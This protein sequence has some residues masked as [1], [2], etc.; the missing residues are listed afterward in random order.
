M[1][2]L[3]NNRFTPL[4]WSRDECWKFS[5]FHFDFMISKFFNWNFT[6]IWILRLQLIALDFVCHFIGVGL[7][8]SRVNYSPYVKSSLARPS[9]IAFQRVKSRIRAYQLR[10]RFHTTNVCCF[11]TTSTSKASTKTTVK[12][13]LLTTL[14]VQHRILEFP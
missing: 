8:N 12:A 7:M 13:F 5:W 2:I 3:I 6:K 4:V 1:F 9:P 14:A 11:W 10:T